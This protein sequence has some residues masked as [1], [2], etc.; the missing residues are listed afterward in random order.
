MPSTTF[1]RYQTSAH[2]KIN[3]KPCN[4][5]GIVDILLD[6]FGRLRQT[7]P[8][9]AGQSS[10]LGRISVV[11]RFLKKIVRFQCDLERSLTWL[12]RKQM[13]QSYR[14]K[15]MNIHGT[16]Q[17][18]MRARVCVCVCACGLKLFNQVT[19]RCQKIVV[20]MDGPLVHR[21]F[22]EL[23]CC[24]CWRAFIKRWQFGRSEILAWTSQCIC[25]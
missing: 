16:T 7:L 23:F 15:H 19:T 3:A 18:S 6:I 5:N 22:K 21:T 20:R 24:N 25:Q 1:K 12:E 11:G 2:S 8:S 17:K 13:K 14:Y 4:I 10:C 9:G